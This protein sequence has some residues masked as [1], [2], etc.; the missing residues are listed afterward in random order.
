MLEL[1]LASTG[2]EA[3]WV[4]PFALS[5]RAPN[6][7]S[8]HGELR[9][10]D[11][12]P[13]GFDGYA[14]LFHCVSLQVIGVLGDVPGMMHQQQR[15][16]W[17]ALCEELG[18]PFE[19][20]LTP[21]QLQRALEGRFGAS[22]QWPFAQH[23]PTEGTLQQPQLGALVELLAA[24]GAEGERW[25]AYY[26]PSALGWVRE[27]ELHRGTPE[28][29]E[30]LARAPWNPTGASPTLWWPQSRRWCV[31]TDWDRWSTL[32]AAPREIIAKLT[33]HPVLD[34]L[35]IAWDARLEL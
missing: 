21:G 34:A 22:A 28:L 15:M 24:S 9:V 8:R 17:R 5:T 3:D 10:S 19:A 29:I 4:R 35:P 6:A 7:L 23:G 13:G 20:S 30:Q 2:D 27:A 16:R 14:R 32:I 33:R 12:M 18:L 31:H 25:C 1:S 26:D 11:L